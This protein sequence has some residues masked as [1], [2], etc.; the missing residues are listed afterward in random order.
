MKQTH[1]TQ[2]RLRQ[3][4]ILLLPILVTQL[5]IFSMSFF[6]TVMSG[7]ASAND[8]A[9]VAIGVNL[10]MPL[11]TGINGVLL[12]ITPIVAHLLG[13]GRKENV[14][15]T[16]MQG[17]YLSIVIAVLVIIAGMFAVTPLLDAMKLEPVVH[18]IA[19]RYLIGLSFGI[20]PLLVYT[21][22][23]SFMDALGQ[24][25]ITMLITLVS[26]PINVVLNYVLIYG[27]FG[28]PRMGGVGTGYATAV[29]QW[30]IFLLALYVVRRL[31]QFATYEVGKRL[32]RVSVSA[33]VEQLKLGLPIGF[34]IFFEVSIFSA[35][36]LLMSRFGTVAIAAHQVAINFASFLYMVPMSIA[37]AL[38]IVVG[39]EVGAKRYRDAR[40][41]SR[42]GLAFAVGMAFVCALGIWLFNRQV[43]AL[44]TKDTAVFMLA[45]QFLMYAIFFQLSD[46]LATPIQGVLRGYKDVT[47]PSVIAFAAYWVIG[48]PLGYGLANYTDLQAF[49]YW[50][51][52]IVGLTCGA[53]CFLLRLR[54]IQQREATRIASNENV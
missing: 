22:L 18:D 19:R 49:G 17:V 26:L 45:Q 20:L 6:D 24:A 33:W 29:T 47:V 10:W 7:H 37:S 25:R 42:L 1:S 35:V 36:T 43:A 34:A 31:P 28:F 2:E 13:G 5:G 21:V 50:V 11:F 48:L 53:S 16:V 30:V 14:A 8:L 3:F 32:Y 51:G 52:L 54:F 15:S 27:K 44:Y 4:V 38:T 23:R 40:S 9:G 12:A 39:F 46:A 41:Y